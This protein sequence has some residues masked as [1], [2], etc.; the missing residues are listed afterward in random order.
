MFELPTSIEINNKSYKIRNKGDYRMVVDC[1]K[2]LADEELDKT[3]RVLSSLV[4][5]YDELESEYDIFDV[6]GDSLEEAVLKMYDFFNCGEE[7]IGSTQHHKLIDWDKDSQLISSA[8]NK[9]SNI[10]IRS[11]EYCHWWTFMGYY[12]SV[13]ESALSTVVSIRNKIATH[14]SLDKWEKD[15]K[16]DNPNYF[17]WD[18]RTVEEKELDDV[19]RKIWN[20]E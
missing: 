6:F 3:M 11:V 7:N 13:G 1:F 18:M 8:I 2:A 15:F 19:I 12:L 20:N 9:V 14:K 16:K 17:I 4:I 10:E 5:F